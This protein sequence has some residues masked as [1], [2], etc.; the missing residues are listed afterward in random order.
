MT[1]AL[2]MIWAQAH[3]RVI[4]RDGAIP[5]H[6]PEDLAHFKATTDGCPVI[7]G[8]ASWY[9]LPE[10]VRPLPGR[11]NVV[12]ST[13]A[14]FHPD[15]AEV[16]RSLD[17]ALALVDAEP[18]A[19]ICGGAK[20]YEQALDRAD[21]LVVTDVDLDV[22]GDAHAPELDAAWDIAEQRAWETSRTGLRYRITTYRRAG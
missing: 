5:W 20:V 8:R 21:V 1:V 6:L 17:E 19:W 12:L 14:D 10:Q 22:E 2:G 3:G 13:R 18:E 4:G 11:R 9:A 7:M 16:A 15:G